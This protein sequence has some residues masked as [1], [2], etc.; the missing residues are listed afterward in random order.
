MSKKMIQVD[1][2]YMSMSK[3][4]K[5]KTH[6]KRERL[7]KTNISNTSAMRKK[8]LN[9]IKDYQNKSEEPEKLHN[10]TRTK[11]YNNDDNDRND[12]NDD[13]DDFSSEFNK[14][15]QFLSNLSSKNKKHTHKRK[16]KSN[17]SPTIPSPDHIKET[18]LENIHVSTELPAE[19][20]DDSKMRIP[21]SS[22]SLKKYSKTPQYSCLKNGS[23]PTYKEWKRN[24]QKNPDFLK[25]PQVSKTEHLNEREMALIKVKENFQKK[26]AED[27]LK[28]TT[29]MVNIELPKEVQPETQPIDNK[30]E[31]QT[32]NS[33]NVP[34]TEHRIKTTKYKLGKNKTHKQVG[35]LIKNKD[36][37]KRVSKEKDSLKKISILEVK[38]YLKKCNLLK[39]GSDA[40]PDVLRTM[41]EQAVLAGDVNNKAKD[42]L[43]H[44]YYN[45]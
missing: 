21:T 39:S 18:S 5:M 45:N 2:K 8:L 19:L 33:N 43:V 29:P 4:G 25:E 17:S 12:G 35:V 22:H 28:K 37:R 30:V 7:K 16:G 15:L 3:I 44:N 42:T 31:T 27:S 26:K 36:T 13:N 34:H 11:S 40:P 9:K 32:I 10:K 41:Y 24:T 23:K 14:S 1:P 6:K 20:L 38:N